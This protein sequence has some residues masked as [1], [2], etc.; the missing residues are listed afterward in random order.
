MTQPCID[1]CIFLL[2]KMQNAQNDLATT[3][4][5]R[6]VVIKYKVSEKKGVAKNKHAEAL[7]SETT[8][9]ET[10]GFLVRALFLSKFS[11]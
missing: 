10:W 4:V 5:K 6:K 9:R 11:Y 3:F 8:S 2:Q 7:R 1:D